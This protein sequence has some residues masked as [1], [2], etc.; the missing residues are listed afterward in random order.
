MKRVKQTYNFQALG[1]MDR[2][3]FLKAVPIGLINGKIFSFS[4]PSLTAAIVGENSRQWDYEHPERWGDSPE[5]RV[6]KT[7]NQQSPID[8]DSSTKFDLKPVE[9]HYRDIPLQIINNG[10]TIRV[11]NKLENFIVL[12]GKR[13]DLSQFHF[14]HP[15]EHTVE[16]KSYPMEI[17]FVH[18]DRQGSLAVLAVFLKEGM[19]NKALKPIFDFIPSQKSSEKYLG[20]VRVSTSKLLPPKLDSY[21]YSGS[22]TTPPCSENV[23]WVVFKEPLEISPKQFQQFEQI[24]HF[25][26]RPRQAID[27]RSILTS[28]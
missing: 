26:A 2:R 9:I 17:H 3:S 4:F 10:K 27:R 22:L 12:D 13:F 28:G 5:Y 7:G 23:S 16:G 18:Q 24:I 1:L 21:R 20:D 11:N 6:C 15:S 14:H 25:N 8:L 19:E